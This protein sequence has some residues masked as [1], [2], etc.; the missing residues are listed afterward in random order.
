[1]KINHL[2]SSDTNSEP[3]DNQLGTSC[4][5][6]FSSVHQLTDNLLELLSVKKNPEVSLYKTKAKLR[7][8]SQ[9]L[10]QLW[11]GLNRKGGGSLRSTRKVTR[12]AEVRKIGK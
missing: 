9:P 10:Q 8:R 7:R 6:R 2:N 3:Y 5:M 12:G 11:E 1:M 4:A